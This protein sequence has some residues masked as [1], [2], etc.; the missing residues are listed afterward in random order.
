[1]NR[2]LSPPPSSTTNDDSKPSSPTSTSVIK[3][4]RKRAKISNV[5]KYFN[6]SGDKKLAKCLTCGKE[7][8]TSGNTTNLKDHLLRAHPMLQQEIE[9][10]SSRSSTITNHECDNTSKSGTTTSTSASTSARSSTKSVESFF[11]R[12][13]MYSNE[14]KQKN[15]IDHALAL[16][17]AVDYQPFNIVND[18]GF[19]NFVNVLDPRYTLPSKT[20]IR[21]KLIGDMYDSIKK[22]LLSELNNVKFVAITADLWSSRNSEGFLTVTCHYINE[23][24]VLK[25]AV[26]STKPLEGSPNHTAEN[27]ASNLK[28]VFEEWDLLK[29]IICIVTDNA[30]NIVKACEI[31]KIRNLPC[32]AHTLN[33]VVHDGLKADCIKDVFH[34]CKDIV[35]YFK[36]SDLATSTLKKEQ[37]LPE[38]LKL[39]Q[40]CPTRWNSSLYMFRR[41]LE[42]NEAIARSLLSLRKAPQPL[43]IEH[44]CILKDII[45][46]LSCCEQATEKLSGANYVTSS[47][48]IPITFGIYRQLSFMKDKLETPEGSAFCNIIL[49]SVV[50]RLFPYEGRSTTR[51]STLVD[52]RFKKEGFR[53]AEN[54]NQAAILLESE[55]TMIL[56]KPQN[57]VSENRYDVS[58]TST[59]SSSSDNLL[60]FLQ[61]R[62]ESK[63]QSTTVDVII[64]KRHYLESPNCSQDTDPLIFWK[65]INIFLKLFYFVVL[66]LLKYVHNI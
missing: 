5:W 27:L 21:N 25:T 36:S 39:I 6:K 18:V 51:L 13:I 44:V 10:E 65:V 29:K 47:L 2:S 11:Q 14:S 49:N 37:N 38:P 34:T 17:I 4:G 54:A 43:T 28:S 16:M 35:K 66:I 15:E 52:P 58:N 3:S 30:Y 56:K 9:I 57:N 61:E 55:I 20:T 60:C 24:F 8:K 26:L 63:I 41:I 40:E 48:I 45:K 31:L 50:S 32:Y 19:K 62:I 7:Y 12:S 23:E 46:V 22:K 42:L 53:I 64:T 59:R 33:L 1:M